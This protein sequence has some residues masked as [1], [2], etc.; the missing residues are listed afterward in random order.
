MTERRETRKKEI[1][2][3]SLFSLAFG[4]IIGVGWVTV[5]GNSDGYMDFPGRS[6][7]GNHRI[8][9]RWPPHGGDRSLLCRG[10]YDVSGLGG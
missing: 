6:T 2:L 8:H 1:D 4:T 7:R 5:M 3:R 10:R 9:R